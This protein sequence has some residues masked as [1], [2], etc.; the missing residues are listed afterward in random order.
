MHPS[1]GARVEQPVCTPGAKKG[2]QASWELVL[3]VSHEHVEGE[4]EQWLTV[5]EC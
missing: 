2:C 4:D 1:L 5:H 3:L